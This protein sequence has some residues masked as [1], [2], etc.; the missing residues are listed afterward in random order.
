MCEQGGQDALMHSYIIYLFKCKKLKIYSKIRFDNNK[1]I[2]S[3]KRCV[4]SLRIPCSSIFLQYCSL[5]LLIHTYIY[6]YVY[7]YII[8]IY[9][10]MY[11][12]IC[13]LSFANCSF[14]LIISTRRTSER[15]NCL[16]E[17]REQRVWK[18]N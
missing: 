8:T 11:E 18:I 2:Y 14:R 15:V 1:F 17:K 4:I 13:A 6:L 10:Y 9:M 7:V 12:I 5:A 16:R 3:T